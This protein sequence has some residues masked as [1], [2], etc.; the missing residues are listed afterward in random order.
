LTKEELWDSEEELRKYVET[1]NNYKKLLKGEIGINL[2]QTHTAMSL[3]VMEDWVKYVFE[4]AEAMLGDELRED[5]SMPRM[6]AD[7]YAFCAGRTHNLWG[8]DRNQDTPQCELFYDI[9]RWMR[10]PVDSPLHAYRS[11]NPVTY[12]FIFSEAKKEEMAALINR[13]GTTPTG[14][15]R[16]IV[17]MSE[18]RIWR[19]PLAVKNEMSPSTY[20]WTADAEANL[21]ALVYSKLTGRS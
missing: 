10:G 13:Y 12:S 9:S 15:G 6:W 19:E 1:D 18:S 16:I 17:Q 14:I 21:P 7:I 20:K 11:S 5:S 4:S 8:D 3:A 2:I